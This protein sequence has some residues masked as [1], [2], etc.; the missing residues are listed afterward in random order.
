MEPLMNAVKAAA[1]DVATLEETKTFLLDENQRRLFAEKINNDSPKA[2][3]L[4][5]PGMTNE[6]Y[7]NLRKI[8]NG[9]QI[10]ATNA[11]IVA[12][13]GRAG[14]LSLVK[15]EEPTNPIVPA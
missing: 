2:G 1:H 14:G 10:D 12:R 6:V 15:A 9:R 5:I 4:A 7:D 8:L 13:R 11:K 3:F